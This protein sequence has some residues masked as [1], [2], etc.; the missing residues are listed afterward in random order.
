[1]NNHDPI[2]ETSM[3]EKA[4]QIL[5]ST[6]RTGGSH[7][8]SENSPFLL[9]GLLICSHCG[10]RLWGGQGRKGRGYQ[11]DPQVCGKSFVDELDL[12]DILY[13][14]I[15]RE[16]MPPKMTKEL[17][18]KARR[19]ELTE[20]DLPEGFTKLK[21]LLFGKSTKASRRADVDRTNADKKKLV[22]AIEKARR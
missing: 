21:H 10:N 20:Q 12:V 2:I 18:K 19:G 7:Y 14:E 6:G 4:H 3:F 17:F 13:N 5:E 16:F 8:T 9:H 22:G 11:C 15:E 1:K